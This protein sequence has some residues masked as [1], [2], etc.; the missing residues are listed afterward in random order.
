MTPLAT[1]LGEI[2]GKGAVDVGEYSARLSQLHPGT[3]LDVALQATPQELDAMC[4]ESH[5]HLNGFDK[6]SLPPVFGRQER[7]RLHMWPGG[8]SG[9]DIE[10]DAHNHR[11]HLASRILVGT[12]RNTVYTVMPGTSR[13]H[14]RH[15]LDKADFG[16]AHFVD[17]GSVDLA[18]ASTNEYSA[19]AVYTLPYDA[20]H[21]A[22][23]VPGASGPTATLALELA[24]VRA[25][26]DVYPAE[27]E[28]PSG[29]TMH[30]PRFSPE[31]VRDRLRRLRRS[32]AVES[33]R[34]I[35][36]QAYER[37]GFKHHVWYVPYHL[38]LV[39]RIALE[40][41]RYYPSADRDTLV[42]LVWM[43]DYGKAL[44]NAS[45]NDVTLSEGRRRLVE[46]GFDRAFVDRVVSFADMLDRSTEIDLT[47]APIEV[48][49]ASSADGCAHLIGPFYHLHWWE[50]PKISYGELMT[51]NLRKLNKD[52]TR[53]IVLPEA[54]AAFR[55]RYLSLR[56]QA[57]EFPERF[58]VDGVDG[59]P[60]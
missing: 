10:S 6:L 53:K 7:L 23:R 18:V 2:L 24:P 20:I 31:E 27:A 40:L 25:E 42:S 1:L 55:T 54:H 57:G 14:F 9:R 17:A 34:N 43:H 38:E 11:W 49:I 39:E 59:T 22:Q 37:P 21:T 28:R 13:R 45:A 48:R 32:L 51:E 36:R 41:H 12:L 44:R 4:V 16:Y 26:T 50:N 30:P 19:G 3:L 15:V 8:E 35:M 46:C 52:W 29:K 60:W 5:P 58:I 33:F 56:E 47:R